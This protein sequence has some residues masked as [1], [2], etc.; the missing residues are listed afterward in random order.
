MYRRAQVSSLS[1]SNVQQCCVVSVQLREG[2]G[3]EV[4]F[5]RGPSA[6]FIINVVI[7]VVVSVSLS[8][9]TPGRLHNRERVFLISIPIYNCTIFCS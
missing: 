8:Q 5:G 4:K 7:D 9:T 2:Y 3:C 6:L 1:L